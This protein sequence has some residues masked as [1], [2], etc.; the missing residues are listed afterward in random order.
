MVSTI[1]LAL[2]TNHRLGRGAWCRLLFRLTFSSDL[3]ECLPIECERIARRL[4]D[5]SNGGADELND[6]LGAEA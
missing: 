6:D 3:D 2:P 5:W 1:S 4:P